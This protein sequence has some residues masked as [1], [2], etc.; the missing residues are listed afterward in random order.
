MTR[1]T[2]TFALLVAALALVGSVAGPGLRAQGYFFPNAYW[3][4][5]GACNSAVSANGTGTNGLTTTGAST[6]P[7]VQAQTNNTGTNTHT[8]ICSI[9]PPTPIVVAS[10]TSGI[11]ITDAVFFYGVQTTGLGTQVAVLASGTMN[12]SIVF[13]TI[14]YP[15][16]AASETPSTVTPVRADT[17]SLLITP[18]VASS[19]VATTTAGSFYSVKFTPS[20]PILYNTD[21]TQLLLTVSL[22]NTATSATITNSPGVLVHYKGQ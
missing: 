20:A 2:R 11:A 3:V 5:A 22:L 13:S 15:A 9:V 12:G 21:L 8:F 6:T 17:G 19:N 18:A 10:G 1:L 7:V 14:T 4:P 16:A